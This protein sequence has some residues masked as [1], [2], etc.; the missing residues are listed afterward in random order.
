MVKCSSSGGGAASAGRRR[1]RA[2][3][4]DSI[5]VRAFMADKDSTRASFRGIL[6]TPMMKSMTLFLALV[7]P[8]TLFAATDARDA[9]TV[10]SPLTIRWRSGLISIDADEIS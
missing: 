4:L 2:A 9:E 10:E 1:A 7:A 5:G 8:V 6:A 3:T